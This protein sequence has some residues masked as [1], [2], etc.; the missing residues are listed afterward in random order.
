MSVDSS[1]FACES[2]CMSSNTTL[3]LL[4]GAKIMLDAST[5]AICLGPGG[6][7]SCDTVPLMA[8]DQQVGTYNVVKFHPIENHAI[9][10]WYKTEW[11]VSSYEDLRKE[12]PRDKWAEGW[13]NEA[14]YAVASR[15]RY[16]D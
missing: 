5:P 1:A 9:A 12:Y 4:P 16:V 8:G 6:H 2:R 10:W 11:Y 15:A 3:N 14:E 13:S 7:R